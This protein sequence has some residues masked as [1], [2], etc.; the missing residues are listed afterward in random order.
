MMVAVPGEAVNGTVQF[1]GVPET[2]GKWAS[3]GDEIRA[4]LEV[5][6]LSNLVSDRVH[7]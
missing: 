2:A 1:H 3:H 6:G 5:F 7:D 4:D